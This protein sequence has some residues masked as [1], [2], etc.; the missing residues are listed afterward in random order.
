MRKI[1]LTFSWL[2]SLA[3]VA[4]PVSAAAEAEATAEDGKVLRWV[5]C[6]I[7]KKAYLT[8]LAK[9]YEE[10]T[11]VKI[12]IQGGGATRG[13]RDVASMSAD[14]GGSCRRRVLGMS[15]ERGINMVPVA[16]DALVVMVHKDNPVNDVSLEN[17]K[18]VYLGEI[19]NWSQLGG[20]DAPIKLLIRKGKMSGVG[21][22][23]RKL[24]F[25]NYDQE[26][27]A[28]E[29]FPS[30]G[31]LEKT[32]VS[33]PH[34]I[35]ISG[36]SSARKRDAK[37]IN[38]EGKYPSYE[39]VKSGNYLLYRPLYLVYKDDNPQVKQ[40]KDFIRFADTPKGRDVIRSNGTVPYLEG[41]NLMK[42]KLAESRAAHK[43]KGLK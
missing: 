31:P 14:I 18:K 9:A 37:I 35:A 40:I 27:V 43:Q 30:S 41:L 21:R 4:Q 36:I 17:L 20:R 6:G 24:L 11:G 32:V 16:W 12:D 19:T 25:N 10:E 28:S 39:N 1:I 29:I 2:L 5:G 15:E 26:F 34:A 23:V 8:A 7:S 33:E 3:L 13:I 22:T 38:L 42:K